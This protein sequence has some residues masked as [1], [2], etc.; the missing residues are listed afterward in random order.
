MKQ[1]QSHYASVGKDPAFFKWQNALRELRSLDE[2]ISSVRHR[3]D[4]IDSFPSSE[5]D[6][7]LG[8]ILATMSM[9]CQLMKGQLKNIYEIEEER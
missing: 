5:Q 8:R 3:I 2:L 9:N 1:E 4:A 6:A 7:E